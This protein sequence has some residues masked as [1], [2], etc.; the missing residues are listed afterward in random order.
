MWSSLSVLNIVR[1][2]RSCNL[3]TVQSSCVS[4]LTT[5]PAAVAQSIALEPTCARM[6]KEAVSELGIPLDSNR[7]IGTYSSDPLLH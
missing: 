5:G 3:F 2:Y 1:R 6:E 7:A 4:P